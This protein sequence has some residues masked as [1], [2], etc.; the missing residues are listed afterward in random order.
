MRLYCSSGTTCFF[1]L[2]IL[3]ETQ[4]LSDNSKLGLH[5]GLMKTRMLWTPDTFVKIKELNQQNTNK[6]S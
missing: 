4:D 6:N 2:A 5:P 3:A 1:R